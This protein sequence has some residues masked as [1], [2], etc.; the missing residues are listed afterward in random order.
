VSCAAPPADAPGYLASR[1]VR[2][3]S[4]AKEVCARV[5]RAS[6][7]AVSYRHYLE[8]TLKQLI[9]DARRLVDEEGGV[10]ATHNLDALWDIAQPL[11]LKHT[12]DPATYG[13]VRTSLAR[14]NELDPRSDSFRYPVDKKGKTHLEGVKNI[15][16]GQ[17]RAVVERLSGFLDGASTAV[18]VD[19]DAKHEMRSG[20]RSSSR[21]RVHCRDPVV[22]R[23]WKNAGATARK[24]CR[25]PARQGA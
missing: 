13:N 23:S 12:D 21:A 14:F 24:S 25:L 19:L 8:V 9:R 6:W 7:T 5:L 20:T 16:L 4:L 10:P 3:T 22:E 17:V 2:P 1:L 15:D 11:L 18:Q